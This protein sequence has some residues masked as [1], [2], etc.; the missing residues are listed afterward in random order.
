MTAAPVQNDSGVKPIATNRKAYRDYH[1][2]DKLEAG[3]ELRGTEVK[4]LRQGNANLNESFANVDKSG[5]V[6]LY[7]CHILP[8]DHGN[9]HNH[10]PVRPRRLL[11]H[12]KEIKRL[13]GLMAIKGQTLVPLRMYF[14]RGRA[15]VELGLCKGKQTVDKREDIKKRDAK[16]EA[17]REMARRNR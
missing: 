17:E 16:R 5:Q 14:R 10:D 4:S 8:Y 2:L 9:V 13:H 3:I 6:F 7:Q 15:K 1:V 12:S 11:L